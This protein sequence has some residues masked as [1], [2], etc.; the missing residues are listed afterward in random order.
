MPIIGVGEA[1]LTTGQAPAFTD[2]C[3]RLA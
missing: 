1:G 2:F 3:R